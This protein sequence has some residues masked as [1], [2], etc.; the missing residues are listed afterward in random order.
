MH[1]NEAFGDFSFKT[2]NNAWDS[3]SSRNEGE[4]Q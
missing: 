3:R 2:K 1:E 4:L